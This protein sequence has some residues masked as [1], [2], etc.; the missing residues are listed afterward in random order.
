MEICKFMAYEAIL[1]K[2][3]L[4]KSSY[5]DNQTHLGEICKPFG[6]GNVNVL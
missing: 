4:S 6:W 2:K 3:V 1:S 5:H